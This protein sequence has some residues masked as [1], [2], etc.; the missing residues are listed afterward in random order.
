MWNNLDHEGR[1]GEIPFDRGE[2]EEMNKKRDLKDA[3]KWNL[4]QL[5]IYQGKVDFYKMMIN[6]IHKK[7]NPP[8]DHPRTISLNEE[9]KVKR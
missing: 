9:E 1:V 7:L 4:K 2:G 3:L 6:E 8:C 5:E